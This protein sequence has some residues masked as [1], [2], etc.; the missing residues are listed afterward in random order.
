MKKGPPL[1]AA[2]AVGPLLC[3]WSGCAAVCSGGGSLR[4]PEGGRAAVWRGWP[5]AEGGL[6]LAGVEPGG[7]MRH[8]NQGRAGGTS[9]LGGTR[10]RYGVL[11][12][13]RV[14]RC[15]SWRPGRATVAAG[16]RRGAATGAALDGRFVLGTWQLV[17]LVAPWPS[18]RYPFETGEFHRPRIPVPPLPAPGPNPKPRTHHRNVQVER[19]FLHPPLSP[20]FPPPSVFPPLLSCVLAA[21]LFHS[22]RS[23]F[24]AR[25][26]HRT[27]RPS[28]VFAP[29]RTS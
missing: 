15:R 7:A 27:R 6:F 3:F 18:G 20:T 10:R 5:M 17:A 2:A 24:F 9:G 13:V 28:A 16:R 12:T 8:G 22:P 19:V 4:G 14:G 1:D 21:S 23:S 25:L 26:F 11:R 29:S